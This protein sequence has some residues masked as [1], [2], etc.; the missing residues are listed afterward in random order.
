M[1]VKH[2]DWSSEKF[3]TQECLKHHLSVVSIVNKDITKMS[4]S[5]VSTRFSKSDTIKNISRLEL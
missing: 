4:H 3:R 5:N 2:W 1:Q